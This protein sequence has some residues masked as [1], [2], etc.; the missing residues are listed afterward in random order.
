MLDECAWT[1]RD[2][3]SQRKGATNE[4]THLRYRDYWADSCYLV[5]LQ[6]C[7]KGTVPALEELECALRRPA[8]PLSWGVKAV[9]PLLRS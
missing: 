8:R 2:K 1:T 3:A 9:Y 4:S 7:A 6:L 5:A